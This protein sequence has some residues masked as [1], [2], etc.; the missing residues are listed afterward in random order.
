MPPATFQGLMNELLTDYLRK[1]VLVFFDDILVYS[2]NLTRHLEHVKLVFDRLQK[3]Q[4]YVKKKKCSFGQS[5]V[6]YL[7]H[8]ISAQGVPTDPEK[9]TAMIE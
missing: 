8:I 4:F 3:N 1:F 7:G 5:K 9:I 2:R 6:K